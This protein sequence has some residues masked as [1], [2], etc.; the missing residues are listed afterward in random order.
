MQ[1]NKGKLST[2]IVTYGIP[3]LI[4]MLVYI[5]QNPEIV[6]NYFGPVL[7]GLILAVISTL[8]FNYQNPRPNPPEPQEE[9]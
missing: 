9:Q 4:A 3:I 1:I 7:G 8:V 2:Q 5:I 6:N